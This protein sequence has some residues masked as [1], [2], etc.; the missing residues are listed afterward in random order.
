MHR[1][2]LYR[3]KKDERADW[4]LTEHWIEEKAGAECSVTETGGGDGAKLVEE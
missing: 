2:L 3:A 1:G 4:V